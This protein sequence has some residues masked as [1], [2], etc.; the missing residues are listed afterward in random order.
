MLSILVNIK[1]KKKYQ[2]FNCIYYIS[3]FIKPIHRKILYSK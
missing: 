2:E 1:K 3:I